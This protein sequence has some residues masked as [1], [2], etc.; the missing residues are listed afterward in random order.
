MTR[1]LIQS[2]GFT[3]A[4]VVFTAD[5]RIG[6]TAS[7][8]RAKLMGLAR[9]SITSSSSTP[10]RFPA[11]IG[12]V[13]AVV[14]LVTGLA[15]LIQQVIL[16]DPWGWDFTGTAMLGLLTTFLTGLILLSMGVLGMYMAAVQREV[17]RRP[18]YLVDEARSIRL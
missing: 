15:V 13:V 7:Y 4:E 5:T 3:R 1:A 11:V 17:L 6:G 12:A 16:G 10:L 2:L 14:A 8:S 9:D 18:L